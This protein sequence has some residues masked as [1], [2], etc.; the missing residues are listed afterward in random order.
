MYYSSNSHPNIKY[1]KVKG[2][3]CLKSRW[4][5]T[6]FFDVKFWGTVLVLIFM[7]FLQNNEKILT[8]GT[9]SDLTLSVV[10]KSHIHSNMSFDGSLLNLEYKFKS[11]Q[12][13]P[14]NLTSLLFQNYVT[15]HSHNWKRQ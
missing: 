14:T 10:P 7:V 12:T 5:S 1:D 13:F 4:I 9:L 3:L 15:A 2:Y 11:S 8:K 6:L